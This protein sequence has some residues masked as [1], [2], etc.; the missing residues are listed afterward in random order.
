MKTFL[1]VIFS[2]VVSLCI[3]NMCTYKVWTWDFGRYENGGAVYVSP[4]GAEYYVC[5][6]FENMSFELDKKIGKCQD[7]NAKIYSIKGV[8]TDRFVAKENKKVY[9]PWE[10]GPEYILLARFGEEDG[11]TYFDC[12]ELSF[13]RTIDYTVTPVSA[14]AFV[15]YPDSLRVDNEE[16][17][18]ENGIFGEEA[19]NVMTDTFSQEPYAFCRQEIAGQ[20]LLKYEGYDWL[21]HSVQVRGTAEEGYELVC[22]SYETYLLPDSTVEALGINKQ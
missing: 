7:G 5:P 16:Y 22:M 12:G 13:T 9:L 4:K 14:A 21:T 1:V 20:L 19:A 17:L 6:R 10:G 8:D 2:G 18:K 3:M 11:H 15:P